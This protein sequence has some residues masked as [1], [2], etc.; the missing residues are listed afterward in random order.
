MEMHLKRDMYKYELYIE[1]TD[2]EWFQKKNMTNA[3]FFLFK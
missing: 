1:I 2:S 3:S